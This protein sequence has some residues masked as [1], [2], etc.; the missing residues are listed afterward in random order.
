MKEVIELIKSLWSNK[1]YRAV[2]ILLIYGIFFCIILMLLS[3]GKQVK[4]PDLK[5][6]ETDIRDAISSQYKITEEEF[7]FIFERYTNSEDTIIYNGE[8]L[9]LVEMPEELLKYDLSIYN[10]DNIYKLLEKATLASTNHLEDSKNYIIS[11]SLFEEIIYQNE[12][13]NEEVIYITTYNEKIDKIT[14]D[15]NGYYDYT[16]DISI[17]YEY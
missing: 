17:I 6:K 1:R 7:T 9:N 5:K 4:Q 13:I 10:M 14:I 11:V 15:Y 3:S 12:I 8:T 2:A 16:V